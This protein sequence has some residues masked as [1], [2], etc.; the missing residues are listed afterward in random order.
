M[1]EKIVYARAGTS[2]IV[3]GLVAFLIGTTLPLIAQLWWQHMHNKPTKVV[4]DALVVK[5]VELQ[6]ENF[7]IRQE[8]HRLRHH[9]ADPDPCT[10]QGPPALDCDEG[11][12]VYESDQDP[13]L[14]EVIPARSLEPPVAWQDLRLPFHCGCLPLR[15]AA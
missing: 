3:T 8:L 9:P 12:P 10:D 7:A 4:Y 15:R 5:I 6:N 2:P 1:T 11:L 14:V 13:I